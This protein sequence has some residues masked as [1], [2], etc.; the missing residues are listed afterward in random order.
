MKTTR[1]RHWTTKAKNT[2]R[3]SLVHY[4]IMLE[5]WT[6]SYLSDLVPLDSSRP[7]QQNA[8]K[9]QSINYLIT[10]IHNPPLELSIAPATWFFVHI[11]TQDFTAKSK[12][13]AEAYIFISEND[14]MT[15]WN[16]SVITLVQI[17][18]FVMSSA[19]EEELGTLFITAQEMEAMHNIL[20]E[21]KRPQP[22]STIHTDNSATAGVVNNTIFPR[23]LKT[24]ELRLHWLICRETQG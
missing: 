4:Y 14:T 8:P 6:T 5:Q 21:M 12:D 13:A 20:E 11:L 7:P 17:I 9:K 22:K 23:K 1:V 24:M 16:G 2:F 3:A 19:S 15:R 18:K 10:V